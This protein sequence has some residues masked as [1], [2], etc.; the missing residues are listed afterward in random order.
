MVVEDYGSGPLLVRKAVADFT[1]ALPPAEWKLYALD[2][3]GRR[4][5]EIP[6]ERNREKITFVADTFART[7]PAMAYELVRP[8]P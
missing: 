7:G 6:F 5:A 2:C 3:S 1:L 4:L 8:A